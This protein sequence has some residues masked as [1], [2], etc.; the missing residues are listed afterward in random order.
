MESNKYLTCKTDW[1]SIAATK[2]RRNCG[3]TSKSFPARETTV[4]GDTKC[5]RRRNSDDKGSADEISKRNAHSCLLF[6]FCSVAEFVERA[7]HRGAKFATR[8]PAV[9][10]LRC[11]SSTKAC[12]DG[13]NPNWL[14]QSA[15]GNFYGTT[16]V[17]GIGNKAGGTVFRIGIN[18]SRSADASLHALSH[19]CMDSAVARCRRS[20]DSPHFPSHLTKSLFRAEGISG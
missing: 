1:G 5:A 17:G 20:G 15:D 14:I 2:R 7:R 12:P 4:G 10:R 13:Q 11:D 9:I 18:F 16:T 19:A 8:H 3:A 6:Q